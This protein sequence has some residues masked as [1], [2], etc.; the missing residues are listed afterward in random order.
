MKIYREMSF[1]GSTPGEMIRTYQHLLRLH[2]PGS[3]AALGWSSQTK[4]NIHHRLLTRDIQPG[5]TVVDFGCGLGD[6]HRYLRKA[7]LAVHYEGFDQVPEMVVA[8]RRKNPGAR[9]A[10]RDSVA[11]LGARSRDYVVACGVFTYRLVGHESFLRKNLADFLRVARHGFALDLPALES[12]PQLPE[13]YYAIDR[14][15]LG[16]M[17]KRLGLKFEIDTN[18]ALKNHFV[19][20]KPA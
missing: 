6:L 10:L 15:S 20:V 13:E 2:G 16:Q 7:G 4:H 19:Y 5:Y 3:S 17:M 14:D 1:L 12:Y 18:L 11:G 8:A 9:F